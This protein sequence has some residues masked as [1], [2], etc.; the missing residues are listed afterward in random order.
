MRT[1]RTE[2]NIETVVSSVNEY[3]EMS[4]RLRS[5]QFGLCY[6]ITWK[7]LRVD[8]GLKA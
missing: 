1:M 2:K 5:Q 6:S 7:I 8:Y 4:I 3:R